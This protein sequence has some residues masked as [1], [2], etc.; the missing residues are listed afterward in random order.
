MTAARFVVDRQQVAHG[1]ARLSVTGGEDHTEV[2]LCVDY[3]LLPTEPSP[4]GPTL[5][6]EELAANKLLALF[7][8]AEARDFVDFAALEPLYG[9]DHLCRLAADK[10]LGFD[11]TVLADMLGRIDRLPDDEFLLDPDQLASL[12]RSV[13]SWKLQLAHP[14]PGRGRGRER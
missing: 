11:R 13:L 1:F 2:D 8:R 9:L 12:R 7:S 4:V 5:A 3:R 14:T 6:L 10:D